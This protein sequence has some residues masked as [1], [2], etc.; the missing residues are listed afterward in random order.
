MSKYVKLKKIEKKVKNCKK[1]NLSKTRINIV[2]GKGSVNAKIMFIGEAPGRNEDKQGLP[3]IGHAG[4]FLDELLESINL[5][6]NEVYITNILKCRPPKN[7]NPSKKEIN[8]CRDFLDKQIDIVKPKIICPLGNSASSYILK[9]YFLNPKKIS[10]IH[11]KT[12]KIKSS[13][14][15]LII[16]P[17][18]HPAYSIYNIKS[19]KILI[20]DFKKIKNLLS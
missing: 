1:C 7:R 9:K 14:D 5:K 15:D 18:Y 4:T 17:L 3:F 16:L 20:N 12:F 11:G 13:F 19:K 8:A 6:R 2:Y 10:E